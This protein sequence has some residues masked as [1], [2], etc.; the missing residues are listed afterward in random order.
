MSVGGRY[1]VELHDVGAHDPEAADRMLAC[2]PPE[3]RAHPVLLLV[4]NWG[5]R[6]A[7]TPEGLRRTLARFGVP[8]LHGYTHCLGPGLLGRLWTGT[9]REGEFARLSE[10]EACARLAVARKQV[11]LDDS[12]R[13]TWFCAPRW[14]ASEGTRRAVRRAGM[15]LM[16]RDTLDLPDGRHV[17]APA[18]WFDDGARWLPNALGALQRR[19]RITQVLPRAAAVRVAI[20]PRDI[21]RTGARRAIDGLFDALLRAGWGAATLD[22]LAGAP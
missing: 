14:Q 1:V 16:Q 5:G 20:H 4:P 18:L 12:A 21:S 22:E 15:A 11:A 13:V 19:L 2:I 7:W 6:A 9:D 17:R 8:V 10:R 3:A